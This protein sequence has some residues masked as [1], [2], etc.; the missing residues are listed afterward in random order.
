[1]NNAKK[2]SESARPK[3]L[4]MSRRVKDISGDEL[5]LRSA[6]KEMKAGYTVVLQALEIANAAL[7]TVANLDEIVKAFSDKEVEYLQAVYA[8]DFYREVQ[9]ILNRLLARGVVFSPGMIGKQRY[10]GSVNVLDPETSPLPRKQSRRQR[11]MSLVRATVEELGRAVLIGDVLD[12]AKRIPAYVDIQPVFITRSLLSL[13]ETKQIKCVGTI[14]G[15][16]K[17]AKLYLPSE[18]DPA[19]YWPKEPLTWLGLVEKVFNKLWEQRKSEAIANGRKPRAISTGEVRARLAAMPTPHPNLNNPKLVVNALLQLSR[20]SETVIRKI[21][22]EGKKNVLWVPI[23]ALDDDIDVGDAY[24]S[25]VERV[26]EA[27]CR[28][29]QRLGRPVNLR[30]VRDEIDNDPYLQPSGTSSIASILSDA[31][32][33]TIDWKHKARRPRIMRRVLRAG[34]VDGDSYYYH[35]ERSLPQAQN[36]LRLRQIESSWELA[37]AEEN[38]RTLSTCSLVTVAAGRAMMVVAQTKAFLDELGCLFE[39]G[40]LDVVTREEAET[41]HATISATAKDAEQIL[42]SHSKDLDLQTDVALTIPGWTAEEL[43]PIIKPFYPRAQ[44]VET[45]NELVRLLDKD[46]RRFPN[47]NFESRFSKNP[48]SAAEYLYDRTDALL[49][50]AKQWGR[51]E[52]RLQANFA[53]NE[54][55]WLRDPRFVFPAL[56]SKDFNRRLAAISCLAFLWSDEGNAL[57]KR[58]AVDSPDY[59]I[60]TSALWAYAF[61]NGEQGREFAMERF[62]DDPDSSVR[63]FAEQIIQPN[64]S[65]LWSM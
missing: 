55:R 53:W 2:F 56:E 60:R 22:R 64:E 38:L 3:S 41:L 21:E 54:L 39:D 65:S 18:L 11:V 14:R 51:F 4:E 17:G 48:S 61:A 28:A 52:C 15:D 31:A 59:G 46:I 16:E 40:R 44:N 5:L 43:L 63:A 36:C 8:N 62:R 23:G 7:Q 49:F 12:Y 32:K 26:G 29:V 19:L 24:A 57:L 30:E 37:Y 25:D 34:R 9:A 20:T 13:V 50:I 1:M 58:I 35:D 27:L 10:Y 45:P 33:E 6:N 47:P 42:S